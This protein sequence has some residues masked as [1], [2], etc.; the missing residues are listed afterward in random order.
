[1]EEYPRLFA[2]LLAAALAINALLL[3]TQVPF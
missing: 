2:M 1:M 3:I